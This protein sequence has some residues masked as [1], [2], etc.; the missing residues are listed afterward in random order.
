MGTDQHIP[1]TFDKTTVNQSVH[2]LSPR[3]EPIS[4]EALY[5]FVES[6]S[7]S[8]TSGNWCFRPAL[9]EVSRRDN[10]PSQLAGGHLPESIDFQSNQFEPSK[11]TQ[12]A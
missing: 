9:D 10:V 8:F 7:R 2:K 1:D 5:R 6:S 3:T 4:A 11:S 12:E